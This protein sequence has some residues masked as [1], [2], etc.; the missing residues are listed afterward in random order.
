[1]CIESAYPMTH[2][3]DFFFFLNFFIFFF[4]QNVNSKRFSLPTPTPPNHLFSLY[5]YIHSG[6][7]VE[8]KTDRSTFMICTEG[9]VTDDNRASL[10]EMEREWDTEGRD[11]KI[12]KKCR[13]DPEAEDCHLEVV[14]PSFQTEN[15]EYFVGRMNGTEYC[16]LKTSK[17]WLKMF[18]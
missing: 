11:K 8:A 7:V 4:F 6:D 16:R 3:I 5:L 9:Q 2:C 17:E 1:M 18:F 12:S 10:D 13:E 15:D 14:P